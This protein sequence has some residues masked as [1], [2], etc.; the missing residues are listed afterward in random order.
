[1]RM[2]LILVPMPSYYMTI[3]ILRPQSQLQIW[4]T[5]TCPKYKMRD[6]YLEREHLKEKNYLKE[7][8]HLEKNYL[9]ENLLKENHLEKDYLEDKSEE[10]KDGIT[11]KGLPKGLVLSFVK[12]VDG[13]EEYHYEYSEL[14]KSFED[15]QLW[16]K[17]KIQNYSSEYNKIV[18]HWWRIEHYE[19][20]LVYRDRDWWLD[21][22]PKILDFY[23]LKNSYHEDF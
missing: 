8:N 5:S 9:E 10:K 15:I 18:H 14:N 7:E 2:T 13:K 19:C 4:S 22:M 16:A 3:G 17:N 20:T 23:K 1:M 12:N 21:T 11:S 6:P